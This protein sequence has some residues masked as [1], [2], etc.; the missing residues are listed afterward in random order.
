MV[1]PLT[2]HKK[3]VLQNLGAWRISFPTAG[4]GKIYNA[5]VYHISA[6]VLK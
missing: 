6:G 4:G 3:A 1:I 2:H 5:Q